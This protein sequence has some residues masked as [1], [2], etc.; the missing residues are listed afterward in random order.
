VRIPFL[1]AEPRHTGDNAG[2]I[3]FAAWADR[4]GSEVAANLALRIEPSATL[5]C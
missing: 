5:V 1:A 3:A 2:M 4:A